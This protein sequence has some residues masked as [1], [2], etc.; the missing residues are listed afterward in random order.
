MDRIVRGIIVA[1]FL[2][3]TATNAIAQQQAPGPRKDQPSVEQREAVIKKMDAVRIARLTEALKLDEKTAA[4]FIPAITALEHKRRNLMRE[5][6][7]IM[8]EIRLL[9]NASPTDEGKLKTAVSRIEKNRKE[10]SNQ[11]NKEFDSARSS[12]TVEQMARYIIFNQ[13]FQQ[14]MRGMLDEA[15][16][17]RKNPGGRGPSQGMA[18]GRGPGQGGPGMVGNPPES[19]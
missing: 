14:E 19:K 7:E 2:A 18:P 8:K 11:R 17:G 16:G 12:L 6:Q 5:N 10:I 9:L 15:R 4:A 3:A 1:A 13:E